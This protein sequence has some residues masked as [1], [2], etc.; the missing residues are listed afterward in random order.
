MFG[1]VNGINVLI[2]LETVLMAH[3]LGEF[4]PK[5]AHYALRAAA[6]TAVGAAIAFLIPVFTLPSLFAAWIYSIGMYLSILGIVLLCT[7]FCLKTGWTEYLFCAIGGYAFHHLASTV[8]GLTERILVPNTS[9]SIF[10][11]PGIFIYLLTTGLTFFIVA[12]IFYRY[13]HLQM[14]VS[15]KRVFRLA[16]LIVLLNI[17]L[18]SLAMLSRLYSELA[19]VDAIFDIYNLITSL[20]AIFL[21]FGMLERGQLEREVEIIN[22]LYKENARQYEI[23]KATMESLHD[24]K[25]RVN[26]LMAGKMAL[27]E[28]ERKDISDQIFIFDSAVQTGNETL[29]I[30]LTEKRMLCHQYGIQLDCM[31]DGSRLAFMDVHDIYSLF[32]NAFSNAIEATF[33]QSDDEPKLISLVIRETNGYLSIHLE[34][35]F[36]DTVTFRDAVPMSKK[37][38]PNAHGFGVKSM[39][40]LTE[41]YGGTM[42]ITVRDAMFHLDIL[43]PNR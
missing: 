43:F 31:V 37:E 5:R 36:S 28:Q 12:W 20:L 16:G 35:T 8:E 10:T 13:R 23:S 38:D 32:G 22:Q 1:Y 33:R 39:R 19:I 42:T 18:S 2:F 4:Y 26:A 11:V 17:T 3:V 41:R 40:R 29:D 25:H 14:L 6:T 24:L 9:L 27:T 15:R 34:N 21:L 7:C 30:I